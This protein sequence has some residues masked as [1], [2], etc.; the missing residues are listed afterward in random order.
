MPAVGQSV[1]SGRP[2]LTA[3]YGG[4]GPFGIAYGLGV[5][6]T[7]M[8]AGVPLRTVQALGTSAGAWVASCLATGVTDE[9]LRQLL[10]V[11]VPNLRP[12]WLR[13]IAT[14]L[15][16][17]RGDDRVRVCAVQLLTLRRR[18]LSGARFPLADLVAASSSMPGLFPPSL[19]NRW[20]YLDGGVRSLVSADQAPPAGHLLVIAPLAGPMFGPAGPLM[21][22]M[23]RHEMRRW[24][25]IT[26][27]HTH[28]IRPNRAISRLVRH[29]LDLFHPQR[30]R[31]AYPLAVEQTVRLLETR[32]D[33]SA[34]TRLHHPPIGALDPAAPTADPFQPSLK[35]WLLA[36]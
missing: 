4:G 3:V 20:L 7:L 8:A 36:S 34:L 22:R 14:D 32:H 13:A 28:L 26:G 11:R 30:A 27:G 35:R 9:V 5:A 10:P 6:D 29:P 21:E 16:G 18:I 31:A 23:L 24:Q 25:Q 33:L 15:F 12:G 17:D 1:R 2:P 19:V